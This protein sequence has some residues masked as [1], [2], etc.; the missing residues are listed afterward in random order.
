[1]KISYILVQGRKKVKAYFVERRN[2]LVTFVLDMI[3]DIVILTFLSIFFCDK[4]YYVLPLSNF[5]QMLSLLLKHFYEIT[6]IFYKYLYKSD[7]NLY[8]VSPRHTNDK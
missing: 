1:M 6:V 8:Y 4:A 3:S 7:M 5:L 2:C